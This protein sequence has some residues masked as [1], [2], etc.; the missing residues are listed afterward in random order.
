MVI[1][2]NRFRNY[3]KKEGCTKNNDPCFCSKERKLQLPLLSQIRQSSG[4]IWLKRNPCVSPNQFVRNSGQGIATEMIAIAKWIGIICAF[5]PMVGGAHTV[6]KFSGLL[7][8]T[9]KGLKRA[10]AKA[11]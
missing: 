11:A 2:M 8:G 5:G 9:C 1:V 4:C 6:A 7:M 3:Y 10:K